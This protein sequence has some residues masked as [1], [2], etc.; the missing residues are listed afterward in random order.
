MIYNHKKGGKTMNNASITYYE[1]LEAMSLT[2][3]ATGSW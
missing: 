3:G 2:G 1:M